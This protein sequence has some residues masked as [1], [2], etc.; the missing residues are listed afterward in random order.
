MSVGKNIKG[1]A[2]S[3]AIPV[4]GWIGIFTGYNFYVHHNVNYE[5][6]DKKVFQKADGILSHTSIEIDKDRGSVEVTRHHALNYRSYHDNNGDRK[7]DDVYLGGNPFRRGAHF[8]IFRRDKHLEQHPAVFQDADR[9]FRQ[10]MK[11]FKLHISK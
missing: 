9:D 8:R 4:V 2:L 6:D 5:T 1:L 11:R 3:V 7:V 10:Q